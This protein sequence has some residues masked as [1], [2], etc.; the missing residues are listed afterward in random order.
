MRIGEG[1][2]F[3]GQ[4]QL[5]LLGA[6]ERRG[7]KVSITNQKRPK[8]SPCGSEA[9][10]TPLRQMCPVPCPCVPNRAIWLFSISVSS[11]AAP[12][13]GSAVCE[14]LLLYCLSM[15]HLACTSPMS[16]SLCVSQF[17]NSKERGF[18]WVSMVPYRASLPG[19]VAAT[20][21]CPETLKLAALEP[22]HA[23]GPVI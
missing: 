10:F 22:A 21:H 16:A 3:P 13:P 18:N 6:V 5:I 19:R 20:G 8:R 2:Q 17:Q 12:R 14:L 11:F 23:Q 7:E 15:S 4:C 9:L 1:V